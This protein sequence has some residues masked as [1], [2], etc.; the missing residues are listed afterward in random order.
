ME[1][2]SIIST[3]DLHCPSL[4]Q[5]IRILLP[6]LDLPD[7][8]IDLLYTKKYTDQAKFIQKWIKYWHLL[9][10]RNLFIHRYLPS[11]FLTNLLKLLN[12]RIVF[13]FDDAIFMDR[14][15]DTGRIGINE[16]GRNYK[17][18]I[19]LLAAS[20][21]VLVSNKYLQNLFL[22]FNP[23][24]KIAYNALSFPDNI[25]SIIAAKKSC[26]T[27]KIKILW[28]GTASNL[29]YLRSYEKVIASVQRKYGFELIIMAEREERFDLLENIT[30]LEWSQEAEEQALKVADI[31]IAPVIDDEWTRCKSNFKALRYMSYGL[32]TICPKFNFF[33]EIFQHKEEILY[34]ENED[35]WCKAL[36]F[37][38][39]NIE[40]LD[41]MRKVAFVAARSIFEDKVRA[42]ALTSSFK[43]VYGES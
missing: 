4:R 41:E 35:D 26:R 19:R 18:F 2:I 6:L 31:G 24:I 17:K 33:P 3:G 5:R 14:L 25:D 13:D 10:R 30:F 20:N 40:D 23:N 38:L 39:D 21:L 12:K 29:K 42:E 36:S 15:D 27:E 8:K 11:L 43:E 34:A 9:S 28:S 37:A 16:G 7:T 32:V 1:R 22:S